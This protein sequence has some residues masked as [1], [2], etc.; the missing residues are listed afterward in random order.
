MDAPSVT[1]GKGEVVTAAARVLARE[2][3]RLLHNIEIE[4]RYSYSRQGGYLGCPGVY[5]LEKAK[6]LDD[7]SA[8]SY[9]LAFS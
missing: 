5:V 2:G 8:T 6:A 3:A 4:G 7:I 1:V 9:R